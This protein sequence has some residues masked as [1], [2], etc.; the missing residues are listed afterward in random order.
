MVW[1]PMQVDGL[2]GRVARV[3]I[4]SAATLIFVNLIGPQRRGATG[5]KYADRDGHGYT[6]RN[7]RLNHD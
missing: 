3:N 1:G 4:R 6:R 2:S 5:E 7:T